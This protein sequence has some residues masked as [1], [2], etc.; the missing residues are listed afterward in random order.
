MKWEIALTAAARRDLR[1]LPANVSRRVGAAL[2]RLADT[3]HGDVAKLQG[4]DQEWRLRVGD[5]RVRLTFDSQA[6]DIRV[7]RVLHR[8][9][10]YR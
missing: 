1:G 5:Y 3:G 2:E 6:R 8:R 7:L 9:E 4:H 10:A